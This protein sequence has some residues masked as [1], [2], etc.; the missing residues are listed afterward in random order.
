MHMIMKLDGVIQRQRTRPQGAKEFN[1]TFVGRWG[2]FW[3]SPRTQP[4][5]YNLHRNIGIHTT[6][7]NIDLSYSN[8]R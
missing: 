5:F 4:P 7:H 3:T 6:Y 1:D 8:N 2:N